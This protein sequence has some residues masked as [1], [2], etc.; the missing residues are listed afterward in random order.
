[1]LY[2][3]E[4]H[5]LSMA[6]FNELPRTLNTLAMPILFDQDSYKYTQPDQYPAGMNY[7]FNYIEPRIGKR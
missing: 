2:N 6:D 1:M 7:S 5:V 3:P 4:Q